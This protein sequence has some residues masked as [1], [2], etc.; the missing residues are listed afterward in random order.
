[1]LSQR[2]RKQVTVMASFYCKGYGICDISS[3]YSVGG[4]CDA[5]F[6]CPYCS[7]LLSATDDR[8]IARRTD[9]RLQLAPAAVPDD[10][11]WCYPTDAVCTRLTR[12]TILSAF[13]AAK[14]S[15]ARLHQ[16]VSDFNGQNTDSFILSKLLHWFQPNFAKRQRPPSGHRSQ[17]ASTKS[18][19]D[20][21]WWKLT[22]ATKTAKQHN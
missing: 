4:S 15:D 17:Y 3:S 22:R 14:H 16:P 2:H 5:A 11:W 21:F 9:R 13:T 20:R 19:D 10:C 12:P 8:H 1:M 6:R 18:E 7:K